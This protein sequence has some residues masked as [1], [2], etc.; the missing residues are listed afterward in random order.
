MAN[1][2]LPEIENDQWRSMSQMRFCLNE[3]LQVFW[4]RGTYAIVREAPIQPVSSY[5]TIDPEP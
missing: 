5:P 3:F 1:Y 2:G 4:R